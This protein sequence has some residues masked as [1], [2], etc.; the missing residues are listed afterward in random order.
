MTRYLAMRTDP[1]R[2]P[3]IWRELRAGLLRINMDAE[4][5]AALSGPLG[6]AAFAAEMRR[7]A[8]TNGDDSADLEGEER[9]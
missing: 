4:K 5:I 7:L 6:D 3:F 9:I 8:A 2:R 1:A